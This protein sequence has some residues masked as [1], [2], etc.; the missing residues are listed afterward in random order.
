MRKVIVVSIIIVLAAILLSTNPRF[1]NQ[2]DNQATPGPT[3]QRA[4]PQIPEGWEP[5]LNENMGIS[6]AVPQGYI[7]EQNGDLSILAMPP[8]D[9]GD[10]F[11]NTR[12]FYISIVPENLKNSG[13]GEIYNYSE[14]FYDKLLAMKAG[15]VKNMSENEGQK[16]WYMY[17]RQND[18]VFNGRI[19]KVFLN[20]RP[21]E[22]PTGTW[23]YRYIF[24][25]P[26]RTIIAGAYIEGGS[27]DAPLTLPVLK[28]IMD[29]L[30][31]QD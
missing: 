29:T 7:I 26:Q 12:F 30:A 9:N 11:G 16:D 14:S 17:E 28:Q 23:E 25:V 18:D 10:A 31:I 5:Y 1:N 8:K 13:G 6:F 21:W 27:S 15:E 4:T 22:F 24:E 2:K 19:A 3:Q 20:Q